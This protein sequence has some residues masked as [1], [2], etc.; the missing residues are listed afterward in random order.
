[1]KNITPQKLIL[2]L[3]LALLGFGAVGCVTLFSKKC[4][5][6]GGGGL[7][8]GATLSVWGMFDKE[9]QVNVMKNGH[10]IHYT[11]IPEENFERELLRALAEDRA[12]D[13]V[14][15]HNTWLSKLQSVLTPLPDTSPHT[16][17]S[18]R[19][20]YPDAAVSDFVREESGTRFIYAYPLYMDTLALYWNRD[21]FNS[22]QIAEPPESWEE[23]ARAVPKL[24]LLSIEGKVIRAGAA[25]GT[26][27]NINRSTDIVG[28][29]MLQA[30]ARMV[31]DDRREA[32]FASCV[33]VDAKPVCSGASA[34]RF[35]TDFANATKDVYTWSP[36]FDNSIDA[37]VNGK[38]AM[39]LNYAHQIQE[40]KNRQPSLNFRV[41]PV[42]QPQKR[43][44]EKLP[45]TYASYFGLAV[46]RGAKNPEAAWQF[47][48][49]A[50]NE[51][52][53]LAYLA[54]T[55][56][57]PA[58]VTLIDRFVQDP[59]FAVFARQVLTASSWYQPDN[60]KIEQIFADMIDSVVEGGQSVE[61]A[62]GR[63][64]ADVTILLKQLLSR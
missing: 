59:D 33:V 46:P 16:F 44:E 63:A 45:V 51:E 14:Y 34:L 49:D 56:R 60:R 5:K 50:V 4:F 12:P 37:F 42:P 35:Y 26:A 9:D 55:G 32:V 24:R 27:R 20:T 52:S 58:N 8:P 36:D 62:L 47:I 64:E 29:L 54:A 43:I 3:I 48:L 11:E 40:L 38:A 19:D 13:V 39:M 17:S 2:L 61:E 25:F 53:S 30:G 31:A 23:F 41:A 21:L 1:M 22:A 6:I 15:I 7:T 28:M 18:F 57:P 10:S